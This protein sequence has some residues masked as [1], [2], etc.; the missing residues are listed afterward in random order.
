MSVREALV[1]FSLACGAV[2]IGC[3][4]AGDPVAAF[5]FAALFAW[6]A[7]PE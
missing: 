5:T 1:L 2:F 4:V 7:P 3:A 6:T